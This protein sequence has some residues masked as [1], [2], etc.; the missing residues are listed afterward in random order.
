MN[1]RLAQ[2][3]LMNA[4][5]TWRKAQKLTLEDLAPK[6]AVSVGSLSRI[7]RGEQWPDREF[8]ERLPHVTGI[9]ADELIASLPLA[10]TPS[11]A[12]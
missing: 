11:E 2:Y 7:E 5:R 4:L 3:Y 1:L 9:T 6:L 12:A 10:P 8:F